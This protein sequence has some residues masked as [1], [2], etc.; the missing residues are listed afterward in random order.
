M[1]ELGRS[2]RSRYYVC[3]KKNQ[4]PEMPRWGHHHPFLHPYVPHG[5]AVRHPGISIFDS[6]TITS[7]VSLNKCMIWL[8]S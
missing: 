3:G 5:S 2:Q 6:G 7:F 1:V 8:P 4:L